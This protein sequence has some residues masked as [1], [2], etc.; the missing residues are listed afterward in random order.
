MDF[1]Y[2]LGRFHVVVLHLPIGVV[3]VAIVLDYLARRE[4]YRPLA[5][6]SA[7]L[8][9]AAALTAIEEALAGLAAAAE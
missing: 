4:R 7:F 1:L 2:F 9:G 8:W 6:A 3:L 5:A